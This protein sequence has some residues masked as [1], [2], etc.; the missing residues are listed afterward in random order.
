MVFDNF[1]CNLLWLTLH[2]SSYFFIETKLFSVGEYESLSKPETWTF[3]LLNKPDNLIVQFTDLFKDKTNQCVKS[4]ISAA[5]LS[6]ED[7]SHSLERVPE[8]LQNRISNSQ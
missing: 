7:K 3:T 2:G 1:L 8:P 5:W 4:F 6:T